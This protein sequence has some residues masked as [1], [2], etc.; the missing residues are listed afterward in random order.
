MF[1]LIRG[2]PL[3]EIKY[4]CQK[5][6]TGKY[7]HTMVCDNIFTIDTETTSDFID[8]NGRPFM[9]DYDNPEK[10]QDAVKHSVCYLWQ[11]GIDKDTRYI[12]RSLYELCDLLY[13]LNQYCPFHKIVW[14]HN[15]SFDFNFFQ[16][17]FRIINVFARKPRH[18]M[19]AY[20]PDYHIEIRC[21]YV[22]TNLSLENWAVSLNLP[23][24]KK[25]GLLQYDKMRTPLTPLTDEEIDYSIADLD[26]IYYGIDFY[27][28]QYGHVWDIPLTHTGKMRRAC[29][30]VME[31]ET[32][33]CEKITK[34]MPQTLNEYVEQAHA[35]LGGSVF[36]NWLYKNRLIKEDVKH[37][38]RLPA[39]DIA[40]S[41]PYVLVACK[42]P[43]TPFFKVTNYKK[44]M[45]NDRYVYIVRFTVE[46]ME[47]NYNCHFMS[48]SKALSLKG[49]ESDNGRIIRSQFA[50]FILTSVDFELFEKCYTYTGLNILS[51]R[52]SYAKPLNNKF[53]RFII[54]LYK[55]KTTLKGVEGQQALYQN[56]KEYINSTYGDFVTK[57]FS[58]EIVYNQKSAENWT[59]KELTEE[60]YQKTLKTLNRKRYKNYKAFCQ[61]IFVTA[62]ARAR[63]W[64]AVIELDEHIMYSDT[65][66]L[67]LYNYD[68]EYFE[69]ENKFVLTRHKE[70]ADELQIDI[71]DLSPVDI[72]GVRHPLGVWEHEGN[73]EQFKSL[74]C[75]QY[76]Y[77]DKKG[78]HLTCAG[79]SKLAVKC[80]KNVDDFKIDRRLT[81]K[82]LKACD[83][84]NGHT[85]EK[86]TPYYSN[87][88]PVV[89]YPDGYVCKYKYGVCLMPTTFNLSMSAQ[90]LMYLYGEVAEKL[91]KSYYRKG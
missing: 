50:E 23:V 7:R 38:I 31:S 86:L 14:C 10:A 61:G 11:F 40:S 1:K 24:R 75:K 46:N 6:T 27:K 78:L 69:K 5:A 62:W 55:D 49:C 12:G 80:F 74:G 33:Y 2:K 85:A 16:N 39:Y 54:E 68:G 28:K 48:R 67:K 8:E 15:L 41:Y 13:L 36:C 83:D 26:V 21:S 32:G 51:F 60:S 3:Q 19:T 65:D 91:N 73:Y 63:I 66:S 72:K 20:L 84:G 58:D 64:N 22:L 81:E 82:E 42:Y 70:I 47:S 29:M 59:V 79:I 35:F 43:S 34:L 52:V 4:K 30:K 90:D 17:V 89:K 44:Y 9:F 25:T 57:I 71:N 37:N 77:K 88:Y 87:D 76:L 45:Y 53:R 56:K 18:P